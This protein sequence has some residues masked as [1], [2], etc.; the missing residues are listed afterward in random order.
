MTDQDLDALI[1]QA[2]PEL[3]TA[4]RGILEGKHPDMM[5]PLGRIPFPN[6]Q[7]WDVTCLVMIEPIHKL[8]APLLVHG[9]PNMFASQAK[10]HM[11][12]GAAPPADGTPAPVPARTTG[13]LSDSI[14]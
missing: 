1:E 9:I 7:F 4:L 2:R 6:Q 14:P 12:P 3:R 11:K 13:G 10:P 8:I 5:F